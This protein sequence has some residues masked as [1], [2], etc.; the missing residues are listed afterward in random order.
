ME[1]PAPEGVG[2]GLL[3]VIYA[4]DPVAAALAVG[5]VVVSRS[6]VL[7]EDIVIYTDSDVTRTYDWDAALGTSVSLVVG[8]LI[9]RGG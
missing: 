4:D 6:D 2:D 7:V 1:A 8:T 3:I 9:F 5:G